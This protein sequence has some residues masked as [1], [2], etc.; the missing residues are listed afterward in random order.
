MTHISTARPSA[1]PGRVSIRTLLA[2][3]DAR[4]RFRWDLARKAAETPH[5]IDDIGLT[6]DA[7]ETEI[8]KPFWRV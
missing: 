4:L 1:P 2:A 8:A 7:V 6:R 5:L 3:W